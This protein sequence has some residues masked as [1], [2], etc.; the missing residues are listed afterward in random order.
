MIN[1]S[2]GEGLEK[3][4]MDKVFAG[5]ESSVVDPD[6]AD[7]AGFDKYIETYVAS[8]KAQQAAVEALPL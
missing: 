7:V 2:E 6:P 8:V 1:R 3:Y 4:L 5:Q